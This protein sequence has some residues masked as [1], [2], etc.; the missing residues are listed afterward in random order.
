MPGHD[1]FGETTV[2]VTT[3]V[4]CS[5]PQVIEAACAKRSWVTRADAGDLQGV[6]PYRLTDLRATTGAA[7]NRIDDVKEQS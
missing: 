2:C 7:G 3:P 5:P 6:A 4:L 1:G